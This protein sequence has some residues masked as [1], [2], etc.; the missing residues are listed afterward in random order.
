VLTNDSGSPHSAQ[1]ASITIEGFAA[2]GISATTSAAGPCVAASWTVTWDPA[3]HH[4]GASAPDTN[5]EL[6]PGAALT[7]TFQG[8][9]PSAEATYT[10]ATGLGPTPF[11]RD[12]PEPTVT[13]DGTPPPAP[14]IA[15][16]PATPTNQRNAT[17]VWSD[18]EPNLTF[19]CRRD[20]HQFAPCSSPKSYTHL[21][22]GAHTFEVRATDEAGNVGAAATYRWTIDTVPPNTAI[23]S[24]PA[25]PSSSPSATFV[26]TSTQPGGGFSCRL[27]GAAFAPCRSPQT[28]RGLAN[29]QHAFEVR[30]TDAAG[31]ADPSPASYSWRVAAQGPTDR[32][33]PSAVRKLRRTVLY[34]RLKL[35]WQS[36]HDTDFDH[37]AV[38]VGKSPYQRPATTVYQGKASRYTDKR[39][40]NGTYYRYAITSY[41]HAGNASRRV[42][43]A[44]PAS[45]LFSSPRPGAHLSRPPLLDWRAVPKATYFNVQL[46]FRSTKIL[47]AWPARSRFK[48]G[49]SWSY[50]GHV[51]RLKK[52]VYRWYVWPGFGPRANARYGQL[53]GQASFIVKR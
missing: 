2:Q 19:S 26:F 21:S 16:G 44:V 8:T 53:L 33:A 7:V 23:S 20:G 51:Y 22:D 30:A 43:V 11:Q 49:R 41:D 14:V 42:S 52:G 50:Q 31:N 12:G 40:R 15:G 47:S 9:S 13:V 24:G 34:R 45:A 38:V 39:F 36:P 28:Y 25:S 35:S 29:G 32:T 18:N 48:L 4:I 46:Y 5:S 1:D 6:C 17:F 10:W 27:D 3:G 37:V